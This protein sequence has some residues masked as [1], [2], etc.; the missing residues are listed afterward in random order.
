MTKAS[1]LDSLLYQ[2][3]NLFVR[4]WF[5]CVLHLLVCVLLPFGAAY[6]VKKGVEKSVMN[7]LRFGL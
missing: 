7:Y 5:L 1:G 3:H 2:I 4:P 6:L